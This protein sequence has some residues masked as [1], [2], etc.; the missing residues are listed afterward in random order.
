MN[1]GEIS[2]ELWKRIWLT[3]F[4]CGF[5]VETEINFLSI[6]PRDQI[7]YDV[8]NKYMW[9]KGTIAMWSRQRETMN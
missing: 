1:R 5:S 8:F 4:Q 9:A 2:K 3:I 7:S 6:D